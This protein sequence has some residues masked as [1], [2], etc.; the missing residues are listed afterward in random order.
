[1]FI[2]K[3][4]AID[5]RNH[6]ECV[7]DATEPCYYFQKLDDMLVFTGQRGELAICF[8]PD[9]KKW[10]HENLGC[11]VMYY[12]GCCHQYQIFNDYI[13]LRK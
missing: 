9:Y 8:D 1:M 11:T 2:G 13:L 4:D 3:L 5:N 7:Y 6:F 12:Y 10:H